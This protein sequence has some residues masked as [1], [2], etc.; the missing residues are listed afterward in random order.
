MR[1]MFFGNSF[2][3]CVQL[4]AI[5]FPRD[6]RV[7][8]SGRAWATGAERRRAAGHFGSSSKRQEDEQMHSSCSARAK[9]RKMLV[10]A[11]AAAVGAMTVGSGVARAADGQ[12]TGTAAG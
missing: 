12:W 11:A 2:A 9:S 8:N 10:L 1:M 5:R 3:I 6:A 4:P 7:I